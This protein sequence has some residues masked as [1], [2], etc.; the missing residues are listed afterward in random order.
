MCIRDR[1]NSPSFLDYNN[2]FH[3]FFSDDSGMLYGVDSDGNPI[4][5]F[6]VDAGAVISQSVSFSDLDG[7]NVPEIIGVTELTDIVVFNLDGSFHDGFPMD[8]EFPFT[9]APLIMDMD[10]DGDLEI[11]AGSVSSLVSIDIKTS[12]SSEGYWNMF[13][14]GAKR[15]GFYN[16]SSDSDCGSALGDVN[17]DGTVNILDIVQV[18]NAV[19][20]G[21]L[22]EC[23]AEAADIN[24]DGSLNILDIVSIANIILNN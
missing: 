7:N 21:S 15:T 11:L 2:A 24:G 1:F 17:E 13:R 9:A 22:S 16:I 14:G 8:N 19:L 4:S 5:G 3:I 12:G 10:S 20:G 23:G 6:P 18:A